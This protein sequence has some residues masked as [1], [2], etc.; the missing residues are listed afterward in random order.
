MFDPLSTEGAEGDLT[1]YFGRRPSDAAGAFS[2]FPAHLTID[3]PTLF[4]RPEL[5]PIGALKDVI[6]P[7]NMQG[8][9]LTKN[10]SANDRDAVWNAAVEEVTRQDCML[11]Y[12]ASPP[13]KLGQAEAE[14]A[15]RAAPKALGL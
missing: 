14:A 5:R 8:I 6:S 1:V 9:K 15:S 2:F 3:S 4:P 10:L 13:P 7:G 11:G 12:Q